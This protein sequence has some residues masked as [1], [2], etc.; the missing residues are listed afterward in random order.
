METGVNHL[1]FLSWYSPI[2]VD[3]AGKFIP[4]PLYEG[5]RA[6]SLAGRGALVDST[7]DAAGLN[8]SAYERSGQRK[9]H[10]LGRTGL[11]VAIS[12]KCGR[13]IALA[14]GMPF[15]ITFLH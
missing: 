13:L 6:F 9:K 11:D 8:V 15:A 3:K 7:L 14:V 1:G 4:T 2:G 5:M 10:L 12:N